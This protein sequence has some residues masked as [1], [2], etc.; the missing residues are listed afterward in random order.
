MQRLKG[1]SVRCLLGQEQRLARDRHRRAPGVP[2]RQ[3]KLKRRLA[4]QCPGQ[5]RA[6]V[7]QL[8]SKSLSQ[9]TPS[10]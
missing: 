6:K 2:R 7:S 3:A 8:G 4:V 9:V 10:R 5:L 1:G